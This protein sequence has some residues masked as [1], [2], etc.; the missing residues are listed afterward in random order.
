MT[1]PSQPPGRAVLR[2]AGV[3]TQLICASCLLLGT[4]AFVL[5]QQNRSGGVEYVIAWA[6][7]ALVG[8]VFGG[9]MGRGGMISLIGGV[10]LDAAFGVVLLA[11]DHQVLRGLVRVLPT[12]DVDM[13]A[14]ILVGAGGAMVAVA[15]LCLVSIPQALRYAR[16]L[17]EQV[18]LEAREQ[19]EAAQPPQRPSQMTYTLSSQHSGLQVRPSPNAPIGTLIPSSASTAKGWTP[20]TAKI[21]V[22]HMPAATPE[23]TRSRRRLYFALAGFAIGFGAGIGVLVSSTQRK[24]ANN[25][26]VVVMT[27]DAGTAVAVKTPDASPTITTPNEGPI[28]EGGSKEDIKPPPSVETLVQAQRVA[29]A[30]GD[31]K[32]LVATL[33]TAAVGFGVDADEIAEGRD[34]LAAQVERDLGEVPANG[35]TVEL[36]FKAIGEEQNHAWI[37]LEVEASAPGIPTR[38]FAITE[39]AVAID[40]KWSVVAWHWAIPVADATA[41]R[42]AILGTLPAPKAVPNMATAPKEIETAARAAF[43]SRAAFAAARSERPEGFN[44]GSAPGEKIVG[45]AAIKKLFG[46]IK[47]EIRV[48]DGM[49]IVSGDIWDPAQKAAPYIAYAVAN[50]DFTTK[51]RAATDLTQTFRVLAVLVKEGSDWKI[52]QTQW[53]HGGPIR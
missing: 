21:S 53:S 39:L 28:G 13:I 6:G 11:L 50:V 30:N 3:L 48:H 12:S 23:E 15:L 32:A 17:R 25:G 14:S 19:A 46:R 43:A 34:A 10:I 27:P 22:W 16:W 26:E 37:A 1:A 38:R 45:G 7:A 8:L 36:K 2:L 42:L 33:S 24:P 31:L 44:F 35:F 9:L 41:E 52:V 18:E 49:R 51:T 4:I 20:H 40:G 29:I 5:V 47:A